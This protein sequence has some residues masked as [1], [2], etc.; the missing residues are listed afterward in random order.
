M[1]DEPGGDDKELVKIQPV[2]GWREP[3]LHVDMDAFFVEVERLRDPALGGRPVAVGGGSQRGVIASASYEARRFGVTSA[4]PTSRARRLCPHLV[5]VPAD[6]ARYGKVS[7]QVFEV[8]R[9]FT[10]LVEAVS[11]DE[12]FLDVSGLRR[13]YPDPVSVATAIRSAIRSRLG[14]P[15]SVGVA[16]TK[17]VAKLAS[18]AAKPDG[19]L[20]V[21]AEDQEAFIHSLPLSAMWGVGPA[22]LAAL[23]RFGISTVK[24]LAATDEVVLGRALG[25]GLA[26]HLLD[27]AAGR[28]PRPVETSSMTKSISHEET[29]ETDLDVLESLDRVLRHQADRVAARLRAERFEART[30]TVKIRFSDFRTVTRSETLSVATSHDLVLYRCATRLLRAGVPAGVKVRLLGL[31]CSNLVDL[32]PSDRL[33]LDGSERRRALDE[34]VDRIRERFGGD[35]IAVASERTGDVS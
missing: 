1:G 11:V 2:E 12:A 9:S 14:L 23:A 20:L 6:H 19:Q 10:P 4:M 28:D 7:R 15:C 31:G 18:A 21:H 3:I 32:A 13:H 8:F 24:E 25:D 26:R 35:T 22:T 5:L 29:F 17:F 27:L 33:D 34:T 16:P 30:V